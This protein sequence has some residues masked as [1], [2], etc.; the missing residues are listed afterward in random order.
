MKLCYFCE[1]I[2]MYMPV[3]PELPHI[4][5][6]P[7][8]TILLLVSQTRIINQYSPSPQISGV[9]LPLCLLFL[10]KIHCERSVDRD[11]REKE[12]VECVFPCMFVRMYVYVC[13][14]VCLWL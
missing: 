5:N 9:H 10:C 4:K 2:C 3:S 1:S 7:E 14:H 12:I 6:R 11:S 8:A 13:M